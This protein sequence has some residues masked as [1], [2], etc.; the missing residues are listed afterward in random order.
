MWWRDTSGGGR[1]KRA[2]LVAVRWRLVGHGSSAREL[3]CHDV[4]IAQQLSKA[5]AGGEG[6]ECAHSGASQLE[7][8]ARPL[9]RRPQQSIQH[10][11]PTLEGLAGRGRAWSVRV[12]SG[13]AAGNEEGQV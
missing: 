11:R 2:A 12:W 5:P 6:G 13:G 1:A 4:W 10:P 8:A 9:I 3:P 7:R